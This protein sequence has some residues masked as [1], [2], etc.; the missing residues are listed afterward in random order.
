M[1]V[2]ELEDKDYSIHFH[3]WAPDGFKD[4]LSY[5][6][7]EVGFRIAFFARCPGEV[8]VVLKVM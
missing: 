4:L 7:D 1:R 3:C 6:A 2:K 8:V 5:C